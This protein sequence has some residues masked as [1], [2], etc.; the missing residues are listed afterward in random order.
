MLGHTILIPFKWT[1]VQEVSC[2]GQLLLFK[3]YQNWKNILWKRKCIWTIFPSEIIVP[4]C[5]KTLL[6]QWP[7]SR[8]QH[9][10]AWLENLNQ[11]KPLLLTIAL[12]T[13][14]EHPEKTFFQHSWLCRLAELYYG[15]FGAYWVAFSAHNLPLCL[16]IPY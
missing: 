1:F 16:P 5:F 4:Q 12:I 15:T 7:T 2:V 6:G 10:Q 11:R 8:Q 3:F 14:Y 13:D 9:L